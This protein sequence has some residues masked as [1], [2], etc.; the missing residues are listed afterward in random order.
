MSAR[1]DIVCDAPN[2]ANV[3]GAGN[4][5]LTY[6]IEP[7]TGAPV[8]LPEFSVAGCH[9]CSENCWGK[10]QAAAVTRVREME[11]GKA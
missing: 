2:C 5:W 1:L 9:V 7:T 8:L 4:K 6:F 10:V 11:G 3:R